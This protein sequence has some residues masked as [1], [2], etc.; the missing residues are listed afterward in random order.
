MASGGRKTKRRWG[1]TTLPKP[2]LHHRQVEKG[3]KSCL[4]EPIAGPLVP[5]IIIK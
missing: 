2:A 5:L 3:A 4:S 1:L